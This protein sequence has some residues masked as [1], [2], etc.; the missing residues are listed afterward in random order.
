MEPTAEAIIVALPIWV[1][2]GGAIL[3]GVITGF[4][5]GLSFRLLNY[6]MFRGNQAPGGVKQPPSAAR[7]AMEDKQRRIENG[8]QQHTYSN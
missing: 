8:H 3:A 2:I 6:L 1:V 7:R 5:I 4:S